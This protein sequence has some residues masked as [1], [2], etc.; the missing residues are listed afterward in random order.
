MMICLREDGKHSLAAPI[1]IE[2]TDL[3][4]NLNGDLVNTY[5]GTTSQTRFT[6]FYAEIKQI[7]GLITNTQTTNIQDSLKREMASKVENY[8]MET[9]STNFK[10]FISLIVYDFLSRKA[11]DPDDLGLIKE[12]CKKEI[13]I[14]SFEQLICTALLNTHTE[15]VG[16]QP[17]DF[18][19][20][21]ID[22]TAI[23]LSDVIG[24]KPVIIDFWAS[25]CGPCV[26]EMPALKA[27]YAEGKIEII[28]V[29][30]DEQ[31]AA[32]EKSLGKLDL[33]WINILDDRKK[34]APKYNV[35]AVPAKFVINKQGIIAFH[36]PEDLRSAL[37]SL[38]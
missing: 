3:T 5:S 1:A 7:D 28:G 33:P 12:Y 10:A 16:K 24:S 32:W 34:I 19:G 21:T 20:Y 9:R 15:W 4:V 23:K 14:D 6:K 35:I 31:K 38:Y 8:F 13:S 30:I 2:N 36:N 37:E 25:W 26:K 18:E 27:L 11:V 29:S 17:S 22:G